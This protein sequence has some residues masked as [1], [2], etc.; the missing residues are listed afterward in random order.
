M[1]VDR[2]GEATRPY[3]PGFPGFLVYRFTGFL[4][5]FPA[6]ILRMALS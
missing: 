1:P 3:F 6:R 4:A 2:E 5:Y